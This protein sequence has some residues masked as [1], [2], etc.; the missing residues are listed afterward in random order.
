[1]KFVS[2]PILQ[3]NRE[4]WSSSKA[5]DVVGHGHTVRSK[6]CPTHTISLSEFPSCTLSPFRLRLV[7]LTISILQTHRL[8]SLS[9]PFPTNTTNVYYRTFACAWCK[10]WAGN[11][12]VVHS[13]TWLLR[14]ACRGWNPK[15]YHCSGRWWVCRTC[16]LSKILNIQTTIRIFLWYKSAD[17]LPKV[18]GISLTEDGLGDPVGPCLVAFAF[19]DCALKLSSSVLHS[20]M[21]S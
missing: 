4:R 21:V 5:K 20:A 16:R 11:Y 12:W 3:D 9:F 18:L 6:V 14:R 10:S 2:I 17:A 19:L 7:I 1:M 8:L 13:N 15:L